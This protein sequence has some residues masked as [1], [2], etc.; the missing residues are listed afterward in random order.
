[1][2]TSPGDGAPG[3]C[4]TAL[5]VLSSIIRGIRRAGQARL[6]VGAQS[7]GLL[8]TPSI[9]LPL[10]LNATGGCFMRRRRQWV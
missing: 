8:Y 6:P 5:V 7:K 4:S 10:L 3:A 1:M 2:E 9:W